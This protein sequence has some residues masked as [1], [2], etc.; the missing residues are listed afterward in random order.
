M[1]ENE[2]DEVLIAP[3]N[4]VQAQNIALVMSEGV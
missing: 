2:I 1:D 4:I 3:A